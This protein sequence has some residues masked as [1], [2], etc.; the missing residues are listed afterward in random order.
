M[1]TDIIETV[2][3]KVPYHLYRKINNCKI[4][5]LFHVGLFCFETIRKFIKSFRYSLPCSTAMV[6]QESPEKCVKRLHYRHDRHPKE[7]RRIWIEVTTKL[8]KSL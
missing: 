3:A 8:K 7:E 6:Q 2:F 1:F 5:S 4:E